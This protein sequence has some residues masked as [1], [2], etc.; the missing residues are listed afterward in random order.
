ME[1]DLNKTIEING[2]TYRCVLGTDC[3]ECDLIGMR[4]CLEHTGACID[5]GRSD[6]TDVVFKQEA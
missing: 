5:L 1:I 3:D 2:I 6:S 4:D